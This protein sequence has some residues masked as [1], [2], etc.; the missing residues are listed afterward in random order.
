MYLRR[1]RTVMDE[2]LQPPDT[3]VGELVL[4]Q[5]IDTLYQQMQ[6]DVA[7]DAA[8]WPID[9]GAPQTFA[10]ALDLL[11]TDYLDVRRSYL[12]QTCGPEGQGFIPAA[13]P[14]TAV[15]QLGDVGLSSGEADADR[16]YVTLVNRNAYA[17][18]LSN[19]RL[20]GAVQ[21]TLQPGVVLPAGGTLYI[22]ADV[23]QFR[24]RPVSP[25]GNEGRFVQGEYTGRFS[26]GLNL[27]HLRNAKGD[28]VSSRVVV[29][30]R[31]WG[32]PRNVRLR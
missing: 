20:E 21:Y 24:R 26:V 7:L 23:N 31:P 17:V 32:T 8:K 11:K 10:Q 4:E 19:W 12:Y 13:Q 14:T 30:L 18:D 28:L 29:D 27:L 22:A 1:L 25:T 15:V 3:P 16:E 6:A 9:W 2:Q 5:R